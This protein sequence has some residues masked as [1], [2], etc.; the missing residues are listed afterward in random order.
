M[1]ASCGAAATLKP[2]VDRRHHGTVL[3]QEDSLVARGHLEQ[4]GCSEPL[5]FLSDLSFF[6]S[7]V[8]VNTYL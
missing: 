3:P 4:V 8:T 7:F 2:A 1:R 5:L 6:S